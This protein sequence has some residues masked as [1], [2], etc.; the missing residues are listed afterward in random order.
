MICCVFIPPA[1]IPFSKK[2]FRLFLCWLPCCLL[3]S[4]VYSLNLAI[5]IVDG[6]LV[7]DNITYTVSG[8]NCDSLHIT[9]QTE[10]CKYYGECCGDVVRVRER[11]EPG[12]FQC[13]DVGLT[14]GYV[15][16]KCPTGTKTAL[17]QM[18]EKAGNTS[19]FADMA[20]ISHWPV[21]STYTG[22]TYSNI[23]CAICNG[24]VKSPMTNTIPGFDPLKAIE[25]W[26]ADVYCGQ[27]IQLLLENQTSMFTVGWLKEQL[28]NRK[29]ELLHTATQHGV[30]RSS[31]GFTIA[32]CPASYTNQEIKLL[33]E[34]G[35]ANTV[36]S[37]SASVFRNKFCEICWEDENI[38]IKKQN[39]S[40]T[41]TYHLLR[42][43][44]VVQKFQ[45]TFFSNANLLNLTTEKSLQY[46]SLANNL[47]QSYWTNQINTSTQ[48]QQSKEPGT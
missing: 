43:K 10:E 20:Q 22:I 8:A 1:E 29:C 35:P 28:K 9:S 45:Q 23:Y 39:K 44:P 12:T 13:M 26:S 37:T 41:F 47:S 24:V 17:S 11:L 38:S 16:N 5:G 42:A 19:D 36:S 4:R 46:M 3:T 25:F 18:C 21:T 15:V 14:T 2:M 7:V 32:Q 31:C 33:C 40:I 30:H 6:G 34:F 48:T 27:D